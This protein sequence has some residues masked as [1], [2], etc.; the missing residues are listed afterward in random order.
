MYFHIRAAASARNKLLAESKARVTQS[1]WKNI[2]KLEFYWLGGPHYEN[3]LWQKNTLS[4]RVPALSHCTSALQLPLFQALCAALGFLQQASRGKRSVIGDVE[5]KCDVA[6]SVPVCEKTCTLKEIKFNSSR[7]DCVCVRPVPPFKNSWVMHKWGC[8]R[9]KRKLE[10]KIW[11][12]R[13]RLGILSLNNAR[14]WLSRPCQN[15]LIA[16]FSP[17]YIKIILHTSTLYDKHKIIFNF[18]RHF[19]RQ[20]TVIKND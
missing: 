5:F 20:I 8:S 10:L 15:N 1:A 3:A 9:F 17:C 19:S 11:Q 4:W 12:R 6:Y 16:N 13:S 7:G 14:K 18:W 2:K